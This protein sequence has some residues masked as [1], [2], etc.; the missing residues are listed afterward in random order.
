MPDTSVIYAHS[1]QTGAP[2][3][4]GTAGALIAVLDALLV[5]GFGGATVDSVVINAGI[6]TVTR[7]AGHPFEVGMVA[8]LSGATVSGGSINGKQK[9]LSVTSTTYT[10][11]ATGIANQ[12]A[13]G[14]ISH[15]MA[16][17]GWLKPYNA[18]NIAAYKPADVTATGCMLRVDDT[19]T[20][21]ARAV[22]YETMSDVNTG[23]QPFPPASYLSAGLHWHKSSTADATVRPWIFVGDGKA[24]YLMIAY[25]AG[26]AASYAAQIAFGDYLSN[27][28]GDAYGC[29]INGAS[30]A[31]S[32]TAGNNNSWELDYGDSTLA[33]GPLHSPRSYSAVGSPVQLRKTFA[34][35]G[36]SNSGIRS[37]ASGNGVPFPNPADGGIYIAPIN[38]VENASQCFRALLPGIYASPQ[39]AL[40]TSFNARDSVNGITNMAGKTL[41]AVT[42]FSGTFFVDITGPWR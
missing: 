19:G 13:T 12:T 20:S 23:T 9:V 30:S 10:F 27:K 28:S 24:F 2:S 38:V 29:M 7:A 4:S 18:T 40:T 17:A 41:K 42:S 22:G 6:A 21:V 37:G 34:T 39:A 16:A 32:S 15:K 14:T 36:T 5:N 31:T 11:D 3:L 8:E 35:L 25:T 26:S 33:G 1:A